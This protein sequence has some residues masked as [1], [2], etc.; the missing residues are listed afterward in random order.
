MLQHGKPDDPPRGD[1]E[2]TVE[3]EL[4]LV[5]DVAADRRIRGRR[6][7]AAVGFPS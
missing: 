3:V 2:D 4:A 6:Q 7:R 5:G 1:I